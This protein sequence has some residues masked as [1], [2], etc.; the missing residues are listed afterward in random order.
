MGQSARISKRQRMASRKAVRSLPDLA[1]LMGKLQKL[2]EQVRLAKAARR[3]SAQPARLKVRFAPFGR[4][5]SDPRGT[6][7][8]EQLI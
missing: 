5:I 4:N 7:R 2:G 8:R 6:A 3:P 1:S